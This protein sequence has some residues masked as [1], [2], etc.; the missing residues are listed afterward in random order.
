MHRCENQFVVKCTDPTRFPKFN[1]AIYLENKAKVGT[2]DEI[3]GPVSSFYFS[4]KPAEGVNPTSFKTEQVF[5]INPE[6]LLQVDRLTQKSKP[7]GP[8]GPRPQGGAGGRGGFG[9]NRGGFGGR[10]GFQG[11]N[12][13]GFQGGNRGGFGGNRGGFGGG[14]RGGFGGNRGGFGGNK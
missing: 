7:S 9:G 3:F 5:Y 14:N 8:R 1:R 12:R 4:V 13:G 11:G 10:G 6:D 2:V